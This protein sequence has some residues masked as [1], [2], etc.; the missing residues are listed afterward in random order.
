MLL[1]DT[2]LL[3]FLCRALLRLG[4]LLGCLLWAQIDGPTWKGQ[5]WGVGGEVLCSE[6]CKAEPTAVQSRHRSTACDTIAAKLK[7]PNGG[8]S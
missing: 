8:R 1:L 3:L 2:G 4:E 7:M 5:T 6:V